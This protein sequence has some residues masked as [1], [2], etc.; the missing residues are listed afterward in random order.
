MTTDDFHEDDAR[1]ELR[2]RLL[3]LEGP[4]FAVLDGAQ[5]DDLPDLLLEGGFEHRPLYTAR[6]QQGRKFDLTAPQL[7]LLHRN[8]TSARPDDVGD[9]SLTRPDSALNLSLL[10]R[11][12]EVVANRPIVFW[13]CAQGEEALFKH[14]RSINMVR[15]ARD[16]D[17]ENFD[18][19]LQRTSEEVDG[20]EELDEVGHDDQ[21]TKEPPLVLF[22]HADANALTYVLP[23]LD[24]PTLA[25]LHGPA[26]S[27]VLVRNTP[28]PIGS[29]IIASTRPH[30]Q[31][32]S[33]G[34]LVI[35]VSETR[36]IEENMEDASTWETVEFL[37]DNL[38]EPIDHL[39]DVN[40]YRSVQEVEVRGFRLGLETVAAHQLLA[41][42]VHAFGDDVIDDYE[43]CQASVEDGVSP[44]MAIDLIFEGFI[45]AAEADGV[46]NARW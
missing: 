36:R 7:I 13:E 4:V 23:A 34:P 20:A 8:R 25:R 21:I 10:D 9:I 35:G 30:E 33:S 1:G 2:K 18:P 29:G 24:P 43:F 45:E 39:D 3:A 17:A 37:R 28:G 42:L 12:L 5:F 41:Y 32:Q 38:D 16:G 6:G 46:G 44:D 31:T 14:L 22:R 19:A 15:L 27:I 26:N 40:L 11:L